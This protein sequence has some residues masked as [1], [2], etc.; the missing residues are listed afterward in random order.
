[1]EINYP[2]G[3]TP[4]DQDGLDA[5]I[6]DYI[7]TQAELNTL[8]RENI[9]EAMN[10]ALQK[11]HSDFLNATFTFGVHKRMFNR[12]WKW[13]G[14]PRKSNTNIGVFKEQIA[15]ELANLFADTRYWIENKT[16]SWDEIGVRFH[17]RLVSI[18]AFVNG[19]G[20]HA[21]LM[22]EILLLS[23]EQEP[24]SWGMKTSE[25]EL[26]VEGALRNEYIS[27]LQ[28]AD[29]GDFSGLLRFVRS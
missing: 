4:L 6:P 5:L 8:E 16:Y 28:A 26:D 19:N 13:A 21:R 11:K 1:M 23:A 27:A 9:V 12:V 15:T 3:G 20:R 18:H 25:G 29:Q 7:T 10:W 22:T 14:K 2:P 17:H 24:F